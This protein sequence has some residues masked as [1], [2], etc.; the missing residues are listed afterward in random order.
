[1]KRSLIRHKKALSWVVILCVFKLYTVTTFFCHTRAHTHTHAQSLLPDVQVS[2]KTELSAL[3][4]HVQTRWNLHI[5]PQGQSLTWHQA[6]VRGRGQVDCSQYKHGPLCRRQSPCPPLEARG[7]KSLL[8]ESFG[9]L[10]FQ[11]RT[12]WKEP[13]SKI[14]RKVNTNNEWSLVMKDSQ[15]RRWWNVIFLY[16]IST[17]REVMGVMAET[18][19]YTACVECKVVQTFW[20]CGHTKHGS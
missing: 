2:T 15:I 10:A 1:M 17:L 3:C 20:Q 14:Y 5:H 6:G 13:E 8:L 18:Q 19:S 7:S 12:T 11:S 4:S 9:W 16:R